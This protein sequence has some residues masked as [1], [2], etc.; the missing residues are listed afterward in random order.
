MQGE[1]KM[2]VASTMAS[3]LVGLQVSCVRGNSHATKESQVMA[4]A[5]SA[6]PNAVKFHII[7]TRV[8]ESMKKAANNYS[9]DSTTPYWVLPLFSR[10]LTGTAGDSQIGQIYFKQNPQNRGPDITLDLDDFNEDMIN[11]YLTDERTTKSAFMAPAQGQPYPAQKLVD[12]L[13]KKAQAMADPHLKSLAEDL[14]DLARLFAGSYSHR[15]GDKWFTSVTYRGTDP[16]NR[17]CFVSVRY[18]RDGSLLDVNAGPFPATRP[19]YKSS[20]YLFGM[21]KIPLDKCYDLSFDH[22][23]R[24]D[25][26]PPSMVFKVSR[27]YTDKNGTTWGTKIKGSSY[28]GFASVGQC[29]VTTLKLCADRAHLTHFSV[30]GVLTLLPFV[31]GPLF[32]KMEVDCRDLKVSRID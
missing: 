29:E 2:T 5:I 9:Q 20:F 11:V 12:L 24:A 22:Q 26:N 14:G 3:L 23:D 18:G 21:Y 32:G 8:H 30:G 28:L 10:D 15:P 1:I 16:Q 31:G 25:G 6:A 19:T 17:A 13:A 4:P 7:I 27:D